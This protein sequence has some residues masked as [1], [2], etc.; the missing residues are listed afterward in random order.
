MY[1]DILQNF[2]KDK[3]L[4]ST[5]DIQAI[6]NSIN[7]LLFIRQGER[8]GLPKFGFSIE[9]LLFEEISDFMA[10]NI[11]DT[12]F[13]ILKFNETRIDNLVVSAIPKYDENAYYIKIVYSIKPENVLGEYITTLKRI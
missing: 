11:E 12:V 7:N 5:T 8:V 6:N 2:T 10:D 1:V 13:N 3:N 4:T 9:S